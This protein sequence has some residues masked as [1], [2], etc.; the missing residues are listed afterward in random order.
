[1]LAILASFSMGAGAYLA[2]V[3]FYIITR[4][5][6]CTPWSTFLPITFLGVLGAG[7]F[8]DSLGYLGGIQPKANW[9]PWAFA[10]LA[11]IVLGVMDRINTGPRHEIPPKVF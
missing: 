3:C 6:S 5:T 7:T 1:M 2:V 10:I 11:A 8:M 4:C 9:L